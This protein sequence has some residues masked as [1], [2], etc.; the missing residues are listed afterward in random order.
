MMKTEKEDEFDIVIAVETMQNIYLKDDSEPD[1]INP[2]TGDRMWQPELFQVEYLKQIDSPLKLEIIDPFTKL[3]AVV[4][5]DDKHQPIE[6]D[7]I[8]DS[9]ISDDDGE[10]STIELQL[11]SLFEFS[12]TSP[13][14]LRSIVIEKVDRLKLFSLTRQGGFPAMMRPVLWFKLSGAEQKKNASRFSYEKLNAQANT[15]QSLRARSRTIH[16]TLAYSSIFENSSSNPMKALKKILKTLSYLYPDVVISNN[17]CNITAF[18]LLVCHEEM[19]FWIMST[20]IENLIPTQ[21]FSLSE[22]DVEVDN[23]VLIELMKIHAPELL[24]LIKRHDELFEDASS[25]WFNNLLTTTLPA[26]SLLRFLDLFFIK[27]SCVVFQAVLSLLKLRERSL[28]SVMNQENVHDLLPFELFTLGFSFKKRK[29]ATFF[30]YM[31]SFEFS[32][33]DDTIRTMRT[34]LRSVLKEKKD[35]TGG[36]SSHLVKRS[37]V[38]KSM[39]DNVFTDSYKEKNEQMRSK[40]IVQTEI[41]IKVKNSVKKVLE[42]F[43]NNHPEPWNI[44]YKADYTN[45]TL[46]DDKNVFLQRRGRGPRKARAILDFARQDGDD[47]GFRKNDIITII[48]DKDEHCWVGEINGLRGW[49][50]GKFVQIL[51]DQGMQYAKTCDGYIDAGFQALVTSQVVSALETVFSYGMKHR[52]FGNVAHPWDFLNSFCKSVIMEHGRKI[53]AKISLSNSFRLQEDTRTFKCLDPLDLLLHYYNLVIKNEQRGPLDK[54]KRF[55]TL[56]YAGLNEQCLHIW[57]ELICTLP[58]QEAIRAKYYDNSSIIRSPAWKEIKCEL[59]LL[60]QIPIVLRLNCELAESSVRSLS[61]T[62]VP[63]E[64]IWKAQQLNMQSNPAS[65]VKDTTDLLMKHCL[66]SWELP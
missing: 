10:H 53:L 19:T 62:D 41:M 9:D 18:V 46:Q 36:A 15:Q 39:F 66:Y 14:E 33:T 40:N 3:K 27:G 43:E 6:C 64:R 59:R 17:I 54:N 12:Q 52:I 61:S 35:L 2:F 38:P 28:I 65:L 24:N 30:E 31:A 5:P 37:V 22:L 7:N 20:I 56:I 11:M 21:Y 8:N 51:N 45:I 50:P 4:T 47:L 49:F 63:R 57:M 23:K 60:M 58:E 29:N 13:S 48:S 44:N 25:R 55:R 32:V 16:L 26:D 1:I 42:Y 34:Q